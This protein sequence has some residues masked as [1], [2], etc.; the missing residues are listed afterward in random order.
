MAREWCCS[1]GDEERLPE[2]G[3]QVIRVVTDSASDLPPELADAEGIEVVPLYVTFGG[4]TYRD[5][6]DLKPQEFFA[7]LR[8]SDEL[9][10]T[11]QPTPGDFVRA[12]ERLASQG[13]TGIVVL[14]L[15]SGISG[16]FNSALQAARMW[17]ER[18]VEVIDSRTALMAQGFGALAAARLAR[19]Q[20]SLEEVANEARR[21]LK[22]TR[23]LAAVPTL[24]YLRRGGRI[25]RAAAL[26]GN[27]LQIKP[28]VGDQDGVVTPV[29]RLRT[30]KRALGYIMNRAVEELTPG[31]GR[32]AVMHADALEDAQRVLEQL[33]E[34]VKPVET[35]LT[36][37]S[38]V[39]GTHSGPGA[40]C[41]VYYQ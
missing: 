24:E 34:R 17:K 21:V 38:P 11:A 10:T 25:G 40:I 35:I 27:L 12:F 13:A 28:V 18:A 37:F 41:V 6:V 23:L 7:R 32:L 39:L 3:D 16:T 36:D 14:T 30:W 4:E 15:S 1:S 33:V 20:A 8:A 31:Q 26:V 2:G 5:G 29:A 19:A 22:R 9:P